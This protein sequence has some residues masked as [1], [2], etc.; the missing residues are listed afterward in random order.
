MVEDEFVAVVGEVL[1][2][3]LLPPPLLLLLPLPL[4][5]LSPAAVSAVRNLVSMVVVMAPPLRMPDF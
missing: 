3:M 2:L 5:V 1:P 4:L